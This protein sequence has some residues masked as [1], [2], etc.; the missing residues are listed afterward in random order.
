MYDIMNVKSSWHYLYVMF[1][2]YT[3][4]FPLLKIA[5]LKREGI[6]KHPFPHNYTVCTPVFI[7]GV[8]LCIYVNKCIF[9]IE[10]NFIDTGLKCLCFS[11][12]LT[13]YQDSC[14]LGFS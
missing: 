13:V 2:C 7:V 14:F 10:L 3:R 8:I 4:V 6:N 12:H 11:F 5:I 9:R 1:V